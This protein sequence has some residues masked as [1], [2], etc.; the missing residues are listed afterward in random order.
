MRTGRSRRWL[1]ETDFSDSEREAVEKDLHLVLAAWETERTV[2]SA[3]LVAARLFARIQD[4]TGLTWMDVHDE[5]LPS[6]LE[7][8]APEGEH[9]LGDVAA[10]SNQP[11]AKPRR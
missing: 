9:T 2:V 8:G 11:R 1:Q 3:D 4:L 5:T 10:A 7:R 6:W